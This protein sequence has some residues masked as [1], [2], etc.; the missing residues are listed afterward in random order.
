MAKMQNDERGNQNGLRQLIY[1]LEWCHWKLRARWHGRGTITIE[2]CRSPVKR[3]RYSPQ[4]TSS[5]SWACGRCQMHWA[6]C[7]CSL[8]MAKVSRLQYSRR[9]A[10]ASSAGLPVRSP[11]TMSVNV[12]SAVPP[13][14]MARP[15]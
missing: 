3:P 12:A 11:R 6:R 7:W 13:S 1:N 14:A 5:G 2:T 4:S 15:S 10:F 8:T 9:F